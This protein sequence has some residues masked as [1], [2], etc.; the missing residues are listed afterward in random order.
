MGGFSQSF[1]D[2]KIEEVYLNFSM[3]LLK[4][5]KQDYQSWVILHIVI[6]LV[7]IH[8]P[9]C[10]VLTTKRK[11]IN[12]LY[13][14]VYANHHLYLIFLCFI[15]NNIFYKNENKKKLLYSVVGCLFWGKKD[16]NEKLTFK[17]T[18][19]KN[20]LNKM[21]SKAPGHLIQSYIYQHWFNL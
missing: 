1:L 18:V 21:D 13:N 2:L 12:S 3:K 17:S 5:E 20:N 11:Q 7:H 9:T 16:G 15:V 14:V 4:L 8:I 6:S 19:K 10:N